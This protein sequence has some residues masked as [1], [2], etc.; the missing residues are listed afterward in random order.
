MRESILADYLQFSPRTLFG[1][2]VESNLVVGGIFLVLSLLGL[3]LMINLELIRKSQRKS[4]KVSPERASF[5]NLEYGTSKLWWNRSPKPTYYV[6]KI[7]ESGPFDFDQYKNQH[8]FT[9]SYY[10]NIT[11][12]LLHPRFL[13]ELLSRMITKLLRIL[14]YFLIEKL[15][16][17]EI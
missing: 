15:A 2:T 8:K 13:F 11:K 3:E 7:S 14:Q 1:S 12:S 17:F 9:L 6:V 10:D 5:P 16:G 4:L